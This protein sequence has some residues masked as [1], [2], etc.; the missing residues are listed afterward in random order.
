M[1]H[2]RQN[3][4]GG[5]AILALAVAV[6]K[7]L[8]ALYKIP[9]GNLLD[10]EGMA[11]FYAAYNIYSLLLVLSTAGLPLAL[12]RLVSRAAAQG[13]LN[14]Q[15]RIF[16]TAL[17]LLAAIGL[18]CS[19]VMCLYPQWLSDLLHDSL[20]AP[21]IRALGPAVLFVCLTSAVR[22][23]TQGL[24]DMTPTAVSQMTE[25]AG[26]LVIG[27]GLCLVLL[28]RGADSSLCAAGAIAGV[29]AGSL[30]SMAVLAV[31]LLRR[32]RRII[33]SD[34]PPARPAVLRELL[35][36]GIPITLGAA[37]M[38]LITL[39]D[40]ALVM[41]T[42]QNTLGYT[43]AAATALY[44]EYTFGMTLFALP[45]SFI[46]PVTVS[47]V[48]DIA[49]ALARGDRAAAGR[50]TAAALKLTT[51]IALPAGAGLSVLAGPIL[52]L[53]YPAVP[54]TA[55]AAAY[56]LTILGIACIFV[57]LMVATNGVLQAYGKE[58]IPVVTLLC[59]GILKIVTNY[60]MV[61][62]PTTNV[63]GAPV[64]TLYCYALIV[65][66]NLIAIARCVPERPSYFRL[67]GKPLLI[68]AVMALAA[69]SSYDLLARVLPARWA[70]LPA[71]AAAAV[72]YCVLV[73]ALGAVTRA[74]VAGLPKGEKIARI[75]RLH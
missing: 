43:E 12:S 4:M 72:V 70:V 16:R 52:R 56:H 35:T 49:A 75:L 21:A 9:L 13:R 46:Y 45:P 44:G 7:L 5:A 53:L 31:Y 68:T 61:G 30:L 55:E 73:L 67:F 33:A 66:L 50:S 69:R 51:L 15:R 63:R 57:C 11:H 14:A 40:Q 25:S 2:R 54:T 19:A 64:S 59:G 71:I 20:A 29:T 58:Y 48:P 32:R 41:S 22:G 23:Y 42:L 60:L 6:T 18:V 37:G 74:D 28:H 10:R 26:K 47:L 24:G 3:F 8:G 62:D 27:L 38:S 39:L 36:A 17:A 1:T 34:T 65:V